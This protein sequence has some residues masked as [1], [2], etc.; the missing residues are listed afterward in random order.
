MHRKISPALLGICCAL[1]LLMP[2]FAVT[3]LADIT[4]DQTNTNILSAPL[5]TKVANASS[6][7]KIGVI[8]I[9]KDQAC[10]NNGNAAIQSC[11]AGVVDALNTA[12]TQGKAQ[13][14]K[15]ISVVNAVAADVT[16]DVITS[17]S[18]RSDVLKIELDTV[19]TIDETTD[20][21]NTVTP[22]NNIASTIVWGVDKIG[23]S[24][25]WGKGVNGNGITVAVIDTGVDAT[26]PDLS[27]M[28]SSTDAKVVGWIDYINGRTAPYD[29]HGHGTHVSGTISGIGASTYQTG[30][31]PNTK[32]IVAKVFSAAGSG[33][34]STILTAFDWAI[35]NK[36]RVISLSGGSTIH[37][38]S[39][40]LAINN[41]VSKGIVPVI[42]AGNN[43][44]NPS[45]MGCPGDELNAISV[46]AT[47]SSDIIAYFS[48][49]GP[50]TLGGQTYT[51][52]DVSA[53]GVNVIST[54]QIAKGTGGYTT[55]SGTSMATPHVSGLVALML[56]KNP[57]LTP[58]QVK[59]N[60]ENTAN[61]LGT[62]G[63]DTTYGSGRVD[64]NKAVFGNTPLKPVAIISANPTGGTAPLTVQFND[65]STGET[66]GRTWSFGVGSAASTAQNPTYTYTTAGNYVVTLTTKNAAGSTITTQPITVNPPVTPP[67]LKVNDFTA[68]PTSGN[69]PLTVKFTSSV[70][71][72][73]TR[74]TWTFENG[75]TERFYVGTATHKYY[76]SGTYAV[77]L[78][79]RDA[80]G[81]TSSLTKPAYITVTRASRPTAN[82]IATPLTVKVGT[83]VQFTDQSTNAPT[84]WSWD[85]GDNRHSSLQS[86]PHAYTRT[87]TYTVSM[88]AS[89]GV[90][91]G[92][93]TIR[94][95][96][97][98]TR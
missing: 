11:Q 91:S 28:P 57:A 76:S 93:K 53:P 3:A 15:A 44:G 4:T 65:L 72:T 49:R 88:S 67:A 2:L 83:N 82:F 25:V 47:D 50:V 8:V 22:A 60:L 52:P 27:H 18:Q 80:N 97:R 40:T 32:L 24:T 1:M 48:S 69:Q 37:S 23:T 64:A 39:M 9:L 92:T 58:A 71:G 70:S 59:Q 38:D 81:R 42:S 68:T 51:K 12:Q 74:W 26:H 36:A 5:A 96:I 84:N 95:Y 78:T 14:I 56:S 98:V 66:L 6:A 85:F 61:D 33:S 73:P 7:E 79:C 17:L 10:I 94:N 13:E 16:P 30:V 75:N 20:A 46:G 55:M 35:D 89:N 54:Y 86:P 45:T 19:A 31:A 43:G 41:I 63:K 77:T 90:G 21:I 34:T 87:G 29:D 62:A